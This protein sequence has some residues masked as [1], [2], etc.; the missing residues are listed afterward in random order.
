MTRKLTLF[1]VCV[2]E[3]ALVLFVLAWTARAEPNKLNGKNLLTL[4]P[5]CEVPSSLGSRICHQL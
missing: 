3:I 5:M 2:F 4:L 1:L